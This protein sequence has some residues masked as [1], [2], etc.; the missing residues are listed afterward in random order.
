M[1]GSTGAPMAPQHELE[2]TLGRE[3]IAEVLNGVGDGVLAGA[4]R[5]GSSDAEIPELSTD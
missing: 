4:L 1:A 3:E 5:L 2:S